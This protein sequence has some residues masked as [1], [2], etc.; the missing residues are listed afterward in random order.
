M[1]DKATKLLER[2]IGECVDIESLAKEDS[3]WKGRAQRIEGL[4][5]QL[6][7]AK[8]QGG[9]AAYG[10]DMSVMSEAPSVMTGRLTHAERNLN[11]LGA[12]KTKEN[13]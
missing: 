1:L 12:A 9:G 7:R 11:N 13:E 10:D 4:K 2:E 6:K 3:N 5:A 8:Q